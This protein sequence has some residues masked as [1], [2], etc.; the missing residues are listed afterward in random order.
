MTKAIPTPATKSPWN[1]ALERGLWLVALLC[2]GYAG[3]GVIES[4]IFDFFESRRLERALAATPAPN[5][6]QGSGSGENPAAGM[7]PAARP[8]SE[9]PPPQVEQGELIGKLEIPRVGVSAVVV[10][11]VGKKDLRRA[12]GHIPNTALPG[13]QG[14]NVG[15]AGHRDSFFRGLKDIREG[16]LVTLKAFDGIHRYVVESTRV[17]TPRQTEVLAPTGES[18]LTLVTCY[19]FYYVGPAPKRFI[20]TARAVT[21][22]S[23]AAP[24]AN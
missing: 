17:V 21:E 22:A 19:P 14:G 9:T 2:L 20:V 11:G 13:E 10:E 5:G 24:A 15:L 23:A 18:T 4:R 7:V 1:R 8:D 3:Y 16:D 12:V 6:A